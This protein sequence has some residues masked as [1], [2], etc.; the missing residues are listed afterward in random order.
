[1]QI[2]GPASL[3]CSAASARTWVLGH[4]DWL[5]ECTCRKVGAGGR[6]LCREHPGVDGGEGDGPGL[7]QP[8][9]TAGSGA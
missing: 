6:E 3:T 1:M 4:S 2:R 7:R 8:V 9:S 5:P